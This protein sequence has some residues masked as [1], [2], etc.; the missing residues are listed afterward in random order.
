MLQDIC[1][2]HHPDFP[3]LSHLAFVCILSSSTFFPLFMSKVEEDIFSLS[4]YV[5][6]AEVNSDRVL[7]VFA[8]EKGKQELIT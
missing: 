4:D 8:K 1:N 7:D 2:L 3:W 5:K 6:R